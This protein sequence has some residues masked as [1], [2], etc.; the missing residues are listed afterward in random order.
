MTQLENWGKLSVKLLGGFITVTSMLYSDE[1]MAALATM[2]PLRCVTPIFETLSEKQVNDAIFN[3]KV[4]SADIV[5]WIWKNRNKINP[6]LKDDVNMERVIAALSIS[7]LPKEWLAPQ[8][9][10]KK[11]L[12]E[13]ADF[14]KFI[15]NNADGDMSSIV[16]G[17]QKYRDFQPGERQ[18]IMVK[19]SR[20]SD[21]LREYLEG[22]EGR[23]F[24]GTS[25]QQTVQQ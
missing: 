6:A 24:M 10:L 1:E 17:L 3:M 16:G 13:K 18:S 2:L 15:I 11:N 25:A 12:F 19:L 23:K 7:G 9:E 21:D 4:L 22:G 8:R 14:Q 5:L 20:Q